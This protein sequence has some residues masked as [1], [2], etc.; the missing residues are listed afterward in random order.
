MKTLSSLLLLLL[1][2]SLIGKSQNNIQEASGIKFINSLSWEELQ[3]RA[4]QEKKYIFVD[5]SATWCIPCLQMERNVFSDEIVGKF[6]NETFLS[7]KFQMD[8]TD[9]DPPEIKN[10]YEDAQTIQS[11]Y[12]VTTFPSY[13]F[14]APDGLLVHRGFG[15]LKSTDFINLASTALNPEKNFESFRKS[16]QNEEIPLHKL[17]D[18]AIQAQQFQDQQLANKAASIYKEKFLNSLD[19]IEI[20]KP[21]NI[22]FIRNFL[23]LINSKDPVFHLFFRDADKMDSLFSVEGFS[24]KMVKYVIT[25]EYIKPY[26]DKSAD[27]SN[28][29]PAWETLKK[30]I[31]RDY[32]EHLATTI[33]RAAKIQFYTENQNWEQAIKYQVEKIEMEGL[34]TVGIAKAYLNNMIYHVILKYSKDKVVQKKATKWMEVIL[35]SSPDDHNFI[36]TYAN[37]LYKRG[38]IR[39]AKVE[40]KRAINI[41][42]RKI[43]QS[44]EEIK[45]HLTSELEEIKTNYEKMLAGVPTWQP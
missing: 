38:K 16:F 1:F 30:T 32:D 28:F 11:K 40:E 45:P 17:G 19:K 26:L 31:T 10:R 12:E 20:T 35:K 34:D 23:H 41:L 29:I 43:D 36:D 8:K 33:I 9:S 7:I 27:T 6:F 4:Q 39:K 44:S 37:L 18:F 14:F 25:K 42:R 22:N 13:L 24:L 15:Y 3:A 5:C 21:D 2:T